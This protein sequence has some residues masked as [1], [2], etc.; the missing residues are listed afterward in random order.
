MSGK[1]CLLAGLISGGRAL[2]YLI[3][4]GQSAGL[5]AKESADA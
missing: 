5:T 2:V 1:A 4:G 3:V